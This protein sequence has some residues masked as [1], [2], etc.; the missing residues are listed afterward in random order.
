MALLNDIVDWATTSLPTWQQDA[1]RRLFQ[2]QKLDPQDF[3]DLYAMLKDASGLKDPNNRQPIPL[4]IEHIPAQ[5]SNSAPAVLLVMRDLTHVNQI[6]QGQKLT[7]T[8]NGITVIYGGNG[9][10]KSGYSRVLKRACRSR[11][12]LENIHPN[13]FNEKATNY[14]PEATFEIEIDKKLTTLIWK[15]NAKSPDSLSTISVFDGRCARVYLDEEQDPAYIPYGL[16]IVQNLASGELPV[17]PELSQRLNAELNT[18]NVDKKPFDDLLGDTEVGKLIANL[19]EGTDPYKINKLG[20]LNADEMQRLAELNKTLAEED[21]KAKAKAIQ[22]SAQ[23]LEGIIVR[24]SNATS[25]VN[26]DAIAK[27]EKCDYEAEEASKAEKLAAANFRSGEPLLQGT[28]EQ[29]W[30][31][32]FDAARRFC[33]DKAYVDKPFPFIDVGAQCPFCQQ[34]LGAEA[35]ERLRRFNDFIQQDVARVAVEKRKNR[36]EG[37]QQFNKA[38]QGFGLDEAAISELKQLD[39]MLLKDIRDFEGEIASRKDWMLKTINSHMWKV[40]PPILDG[41]PCPKLKEFSIRF[42]GQANELN[43]V[44]DEKHRQILVKERAEL[45]AREKM[46]PR[47]DAVV[48]LHKRLRSKAMLLKCKDGLN[49]KAISDKLKEFTSKAVTETL[50]DALNKEFQALGVGHIKT[51]LT[52]R[53]EKGK[54]KL[55]L[56]LDLPVSKNLK[57]IL[58]EGEQRAIALGSFLAELHLASHKGGIVFDDPVSSL[59]HYWRKNVACRLVDEARNRQVVIFTHDT[60]FLGELRDEIEQHNIEHT[61]QYLE[62]RD[63]V[64]GHVVEGL[65]WEHKSYKDR[66]DMLEKTQHELK[67]N[68]PTYPSETEREKMRRQYSHLR[69]TIERVIQD[70][71]F[72]GVVKRYRDW[73]KVDKL[74]DVAGFT[75]DECKEIRRLH[76]VCCGVVDAHDPSS[77]K[78]APVPSPAHLG[79]DIEDLK[80]VIDKIKTRRRE[81]AAK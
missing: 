52:E 57:E 20:T 79:K 37:I 54:T 67:R 60:V 5:A 70:V 35:G 44:G 51:K 63:D 25:F 65:P 43:K 75:D 2:K 62:C 81:G 76:R 14:V 47:L 59:D 1:L 74:E 48:E 42:S 49:T 73:I 21:P 55:T 64:P 50:R 29:A 53:G 19:S 9:S 34:I 28:G 69:A 41:D 45:Y 66:L 26:H 15:R 30:K 24:I 7:F 71:V 4:G 6:P 16:D 77:A 72:N 22:L 27:L 12:L 31:S 11:D 38:P 17:L 18:I 39:E 46:A 80:T 58:S 33:M 23:R 32:L 13:A 3:D 10:G 56:V 8:Q 68:W 61:I 78:A 40:P 36:E